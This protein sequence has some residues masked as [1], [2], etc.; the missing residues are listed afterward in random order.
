VIVHNL[1]AIYRDVQIP[2]AVVGYVGLDLNVIILANLDGI[3]VGPEREHRQVAGSITRIQTRGTISS[4]NLQ[5]IAIKLDRKWR[6]GG[7]ACVTI[8]HLSDDKP[9][10]AGGRVRVYK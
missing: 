8:V 5:M 3:G 4:D 1:T 7:H 10:A 9:T 2:I 6:R